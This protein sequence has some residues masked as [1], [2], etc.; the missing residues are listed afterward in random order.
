VASASVVVYYSTRY[1][2]IVAPATYSVESTYAIGA[3]THR[4]DAGGFG[5][6]TGRYDAGASLHVNQPAIQ[7][8][9]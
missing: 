6:Y 2:T 9:Q 5:S 1:T 8:C 4:F 7:P 3:A